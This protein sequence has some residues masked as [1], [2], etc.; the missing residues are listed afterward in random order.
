[1][2]YNGTNI[3][4][5]DSPAQVYFYELIAW[6]TAGACTSLAC[7][8]SIILIYMHLRHWTVP[9]QQKCI[10]RLILMVPIYSF[11]SW[12]SL[13]FKDYALY[14]DI[15]RDCYEAYVIYQFFSLLTAYI[16]GDKPGTLYTI[17][18]SKNFVKYP[19]PLC[20]LPPFKPSPLFYFITKQSIL[21]YVVIRPVMS[22]IAVVLAATGYYEEGNFRPWF[23]YVYVTAILFTSVFL[24]MYFLV[25][26]YFTTEEDL[27]PYS[28]IPKFL[29][30]KAILFFSFWQQVLIAVLVYFNVVP[31]EVGDWTQDNISR[32]LQDFIICIE[33]FILSIVHIYV[34][35]YKVYQEDD[36][37]W[38]KSPKAAARAIKE[39]VKNFAK[40]VMNP[41]D[42]VKDMKHAYDPKNVKH[43]KKEHKR[44]KH[45][46]IEKQAIEL[47]NPDDECDPEV[48]AE[49]E[50][51]LWNQADQ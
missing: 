21:Q 2:E 3:T 45:E 35:T 30:I 50:F 17:L 26:F 1:M 18:E 15:G 49:E 4:M 23:G 37:A 33:M 16:E 36:L 40:D 19:P 8:L 48:P 28:P 7:L 31:L 47:K 42:V 11:D 32:G 51:V 24:S 6:G 20:C 5:G 41:A 34:F 13:R 25:W 39:P 29:C 27:E 38:Y 46:Y 43:A 12:I 44:V 9:N 14:F 10:V 22:I